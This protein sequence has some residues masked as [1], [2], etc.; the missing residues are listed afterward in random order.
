MV[1]LSIVKENVGRHL[2]NVAYEGVI[3]KFITGAYKIDWNIVGSGR[4]KL[5][6]DVKNF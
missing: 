6:S 2:V 5:G 3:A 4:S 1:S